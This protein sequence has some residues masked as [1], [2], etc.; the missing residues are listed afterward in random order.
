VRLLVYGSRTFAD[1]VADLARDCG[2]EVVGMVDDTVAGTG[3]VGT[4]EDAQA[5]F[6]PDGCGMVMGIGYNNLDARWAAWQRARA[7]GWATPSLVHPRAYVAAS[8]ALSD[9]C[10]VMAGA[11]VDRH[12]KLGQAVVVW[13]GACI[14]HDVSIGENTFVSPNAT[15]CGFVHV[16]AHSFIG[17]GA[18][19]A[20]RCVLAEHSFLK[21]NSSYTKRTT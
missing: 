7:A 10:L 9:G 18:A 4:F 14:N 13:P 2:H 20:D 15:L 1:T 5:D 3:I 6:P 17:A 16:G 8:A 12:A 21:M 19:V 11:I